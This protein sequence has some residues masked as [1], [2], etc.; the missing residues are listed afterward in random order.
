MSGVFPSVR[1]LVEELESLANALP[2]EPSLDQLVQY[3]EDRAHAAEALASLDPIGLSATEKRGLAERLKK[4]LD[5]D[6]ALVVALFARKEDLAA[7]ISSLP[8][9]RRTAKG[10]GTPRAGTR[11]LRKVA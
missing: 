9:A 3:V 2:K 4:I 6:Q 7:R 8:A 10:Y 1:G 5:R 11:M